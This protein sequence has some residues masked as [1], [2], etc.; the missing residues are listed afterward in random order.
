MKSR[1]AAMH[2]KLSLGGGAVVSVE[3]SRGLRTS[4]W[5]AVL[6]MSSGVLDA[7]AGVVL[8]AGGLI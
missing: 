8:E 7:E 3:F 5:G 1:S 2:K 4:L 6:R